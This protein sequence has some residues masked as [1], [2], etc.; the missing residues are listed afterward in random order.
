MKLCQNPILIIKLVVLKN[1]YKMYRVY[2]HYR[3]RVTICT[4]KVSNKIKF[5]ERNIH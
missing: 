3:N 4:I 1:V 5:L 2:A